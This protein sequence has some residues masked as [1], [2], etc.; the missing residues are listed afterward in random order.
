MLMDNVTLLYDVAFFTYGE[1]NPQR[2][3]TAEKMIGKVRLW[4]RD[5]DEAVAGAKRII[6]SKKVEWRGM[7]SVDAVQGVIL[8]QILNDPLNPYAVLVEA[9]DDELEQAATGVIAL[10]TD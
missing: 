5:G 8:E 9:P 6:A 4:A 1:P 10:V 2:L 3:G 7:V